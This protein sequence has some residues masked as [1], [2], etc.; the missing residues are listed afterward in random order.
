[1]LGALVL[2]FV[3]AGCAMNSSNVVRYDDGIVEYLDR[4]D[5][6]SPTRVG[7]VLEVRLDREFVAVVTREGTQIIPRERFVRSLPSTA[8]R[9]REQRPT[10]RV[11]TPAYSMQE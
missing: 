6:P 1:M 9:E 2:S 8:E 3:L 10:S 5:A 7:G 4:P 11:A